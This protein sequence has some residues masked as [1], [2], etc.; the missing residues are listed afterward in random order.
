M[1]GINP[2]LLARR[3][4]ARFGL[5]LDVSD[6]EFDGGR[7][8]SVRPRQLPAPHGFGIVVARTPRHAEASFQPDTFAGRLLRTMS[9]A[10]DGARSEF[11]ALA[12]AA[13]RD[14]TSVLVSADCRILPEIALIATTSFARLD[15]ECIR[16]TSAG[17]EED[18]AGQTLLAVSTTCLGLVLS[19]LPVEETGLAD[20]YVCGLPEGARTTVTVNRYERSPANRAACLAHHGPQC[21]VCRFDFE[22]VY[23]E[24][25]EGFAEV[26]HRVPVSK[27]GGEYR[28][29]PVRDLVPVC[30]NCHSMIHRS[31]PPMEPEELR[32]LVESRRVSAGQKSTRI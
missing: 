24:R 32:Q 27:M 10:D 20:T 11:V 28:L 14:G 7:F 6:V 22:S 19:L 4:S 30:S 31:D 13:I 25:G 2:Q 17:R 29:D 3:L 5:D 15:I 8:A 16:R 9:E 1:R 18:S 21:F 23:G 26:H 12:E